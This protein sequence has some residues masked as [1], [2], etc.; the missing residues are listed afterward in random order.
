M[1]ELWAIFILQLSRPNIGDR[2]VKLS[3]N[4]IYTRDMVQSFKVLKYLKRCQYCV[5][6]SPLSD[7]IGWKGNAL[8]GIGIF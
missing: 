1:V 2:Y 5:S 8:L 3:V 6:C 7:D 4:R